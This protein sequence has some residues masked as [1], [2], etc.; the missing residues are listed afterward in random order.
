MDFSKGQ[1]SQRIGGAQAQQLVADQ[2]SSH[3]RQGPEGKTSGDETPLLE[4]QHT[5]EHQ[6][7]GGNG[8]KQMPLQRSAQITGEC[9]A[10]CSGQ[11]AGGAGHA[12]EGAKRAAEAGYPWMQAL[13]P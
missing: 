9:C 4:R 13:Q 1:L 6:P 8:A 10:C 11:K 2:P 12:G 3:Q 5:P 7:Q